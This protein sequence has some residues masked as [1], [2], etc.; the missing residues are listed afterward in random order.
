MDTILIGSLAVEGVDVF[1]LAHPVQGSSSPACCLA[2][3]S[4][5]LLISGTEDGRL[6]LWD[7]LSGQVK[8]TLIVS[9]HLFIHMH[10][11]VMVCAHNEYVQYFL[12]GPRA[13]THPTESQSMGAVDMSLSG[14]SNL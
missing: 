14:E 1:P 8:D 6:L 4:P 13:S 11:C 10:T 7:M 3:L 12:R 9:G 5:S 2:V